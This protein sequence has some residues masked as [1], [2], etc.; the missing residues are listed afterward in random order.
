M[1]ERH[2]LVAVVMFMLEEDGKILLH[3]RKNTGFA[4]NLWSL[5]GGHVEAN[6][7]ILQAVTREAHEELGIEIDESDMTLLALHHVRRNDGNDGLSL[8]F[9]VTDWKGEPRNMEEK[10]SGGIKWFSPDD[11]PENIN[12]ELL[13]VLGNTSPSLFLAGHFQPRLGYKLN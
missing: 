5:P 12:P 3:L 1:T 4:D 7:H 9:K 13:E 10:F 2:K 6:E 8:C 11:L